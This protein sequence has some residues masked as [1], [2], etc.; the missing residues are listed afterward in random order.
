MDR[1]KDSLE[2]IIVIIESVATAPASAKQPRAAFP[3]RPAYREAPRPV[4]RDLKR[5]KYARQALS[6]KDSVTV[7]ARIGISCRHD[8]TFW[9]GCRTHKRT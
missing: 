5:A 1:L 6:E 3:S 2:H 4:S 7:S 9:K 8:A